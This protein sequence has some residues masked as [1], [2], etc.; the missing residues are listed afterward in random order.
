MNLLNINE[1]QYENLKRSYLEAIKNKQEQFIIDGQTVLTKFGGYWL[2][3]IENDRKIRG[4]RIYEPSKHDL[5]C[6]C[7][8]SWTSRV[9]N[10]KACP[11]C[12]YRIKK[13]ITK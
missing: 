13:A 2:D 11:S 12:K 1:K 9:E 5:T 7:G 3:A 10:V 4:E 8:Y 6:K